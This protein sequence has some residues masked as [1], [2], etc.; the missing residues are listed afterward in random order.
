[1]VLIEHKEI[2]AGTCLTE[3][4]VSWTDVVLQDFVFL[5][6]GLKFLLSLSENGIFFLSICIHIQQVL[7][8]LLSDCTIQSE[9]N[10]ADNFSKC[11][12]KLNKMFIFLGFS[13]LINE[14]RKF[15][16]TAGGPLNW[17]IFLLLIRNWIQF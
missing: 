14:M 10:L 12:I 16:F 1:M 11:I 6:S 15:S 7:S 5:Q 3:I 4:S 2:D 9:S 8:W 13:L 17:N